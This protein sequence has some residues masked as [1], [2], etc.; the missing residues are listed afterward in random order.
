MS[1][2]CLFSSCG[3][4]YLT[5][6]P[7]CMMGVDWWL[8]APVYFD[9]RGPPYCLQGRHRFVHFITI[10]N[11]F[12]CTVTKTPKHHHITPVLRSLHWL[13]VPKNIHYKIVSLTYFILQNSISYLLYS[14]TPI[15][16]ASCQWESVGWFH[17]CALFCLW[18]LFQLTVFNLSSGLK[19]FAH[20]II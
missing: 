9:I 6:W 16:S 7:S 14:E 5:Y 19:I 15:P 3:D 1:L 20:Y 10:Q 2:H 17:V 13:K 8:W 11:A 18:W 12:A 4:C